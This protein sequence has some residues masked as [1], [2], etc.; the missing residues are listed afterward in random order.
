MCE[1]VEFL[2]VSSAKSCGHEN[3]D[4]LVDALI[5]ETSLNLTIDDDDFVMLVHD[6]HGIRCGFQNGLEFLLLFLVF[7][8]VRDCA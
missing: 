6:N 1:I 7:R 4:R 2:R 5:S 8:Y 3:F